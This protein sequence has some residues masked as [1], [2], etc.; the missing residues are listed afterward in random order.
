MKEDVGDSVT[1]MW[2]IGFW[3]VGR[4]RRRWEGKILTDAI[5]KPLTS[6]EKPQVMVM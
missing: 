6:H 3:P 2:A 1:V 4:A 5:D